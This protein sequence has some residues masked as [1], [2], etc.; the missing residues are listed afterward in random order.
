[1]DEKEFK[2]KIKTEEDLVLRTQNELKRLEGHMEQLKNSIQQRLG[3]IQ[4]F[5]ELIPK[6]KEVKK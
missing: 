3:K 2:E 6:K 4:A 5:Q 1:M